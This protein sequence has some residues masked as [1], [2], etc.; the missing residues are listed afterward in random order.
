MP[1][2]PKFSPYGPRPRRSARLIFVWVVVLL[3]I[4]ALTLYLTTR[5][6]EPSRIDAKTVADKIRGRTS[7]RE[8]TSKSTSYG[9]PPPHKSKISVVALEYTVSNT[10]YRAQPDGELRFPELVALRPVIW[11]DIMTRR[12]IP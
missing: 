2:M 3:I 10:E 6:G 5:D 4:L 1:R 7:L 12:M 11:T 8:K 9:F